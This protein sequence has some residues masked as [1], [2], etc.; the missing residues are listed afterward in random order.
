VF[1]IARRVVK[2]PARAALLPVM[3][4]SLCS[5]LSLKIKPIKYIAKNANPSTVF[6]KFKVQ[7]V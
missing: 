4:S 3:K 7:W 5:S 2:P 6:E 1:G